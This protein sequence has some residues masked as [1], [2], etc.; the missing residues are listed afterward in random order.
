MLKLQSTVIVNILLLTISLFV[1]LCVHVSVFSPF[2]FDYWWLWFHLLLARVSPLFILFGV[3][4]AGSVGGGNPLSRMSQMVCVALRN[5]S[6][7]SDLLTSDI[8]W[9]LFQCFCVVV[10]SILVHMVSETVFL[11]CSVKSLHL[12]SILLEC[13]F[14][15][16][17][18]FARDCK[19]Q[20][21][22]VISRSFCIVI[23]IT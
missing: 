14:C 3:V 17:H 15:L 4:K 16:F 9:L 6:K 22:L 23:W 1:S 10:Y 13:F 20:Y 12:L 18:W 2:L 7:I 21:Q 5:V 19:V 11:L 8:V